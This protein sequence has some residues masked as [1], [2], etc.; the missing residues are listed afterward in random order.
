MI[1]LWFSVV[2]DFLPTVCVLCGGALSAL[3]VL[4]KAT[5][6]FKWCCTGKMEDGGENQQQILKM[7]K[8]QNQT[9][10]IAHLDYMF[11][12][13]NNDSHTVSPSLPI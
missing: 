13:H 4:V 11:L 6:R 5:I 1:L 9:K 10:V 12:I 7:K 8:K 2:H 3:S